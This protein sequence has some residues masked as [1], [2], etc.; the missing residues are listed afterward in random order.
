VSDAYCIHELLADECS[1]CKAP[2]PKSKAPKRLKPTT[3][4]KSADDPIAPLAGDKDV[5]MPVHA[6][7]PYLGEAT[8]WMPAVGGYPH[9]LRSGGWLYL[10]CDERLGARVRVPTMRWRHE[11][12]WRTGDDPGDNR[13]WGAG[14]VFGV[15]PSTWEAFDQALGEDAEWMRQG[16]RYHRT[17]AADVV[18]QLM[19]DDAISEGEWED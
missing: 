12:P 4:P 9:G 11:R 7:D 16:Y 1:A 2:K 19:K 10:R 14:L 3:A 15:D 17:D 8:D 5:S 13:G 18:H 6:L